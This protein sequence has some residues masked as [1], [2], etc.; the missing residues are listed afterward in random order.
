MKMIIDK[1][2]MAMA[3]K[4]FGLGISG[5]V[6]CIVGAENKLISFVIFTITFIAVF[7]GLHYIF[8]ILVTY[9]YAVYSDDVTD[10]DKIL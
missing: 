10:D 7:A 1:G 8:K 4:L 9:G 3:E 6:V 5:V 2:G